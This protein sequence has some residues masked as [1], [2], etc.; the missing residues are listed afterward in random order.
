MI[1]NGSSILENTAERP[2]S[3]SLNQFLD[4]ASS[5]KLAVGY[6]FIEGLIPLQA[7]L[8]RLDHA[9]L[10]IGNVV[11]RISEENIRLEQA[12]KPTAAVGNE[13]DSF[14]KGFRED[15][16]RQ[17]ALTALNLRQTI[18]NLPQTAA[19]DSTLVSLATLIAEGKLEVRLYT[20]GRLHA[21]V[22]LVEYPE[23]DVR[24]PGAAIVGSSNLTLPVDSAAYDANCDLDILLTGEENYNS[25]NAWFET[26]WDAAQDFRKE[27][28][29]ELARRW[30]SEATQS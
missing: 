9:Y 6:L 22:A 14:A 4:G 25:L 20:G 26:R 24:S 3:E 10:L 30:P 5:V 21:K 1:S 28:F 8:S 15:R 13:K 27:L 11:N 17:A 23:A 12:S 2:L 7:S 19:V 16:N 18:D 29:E